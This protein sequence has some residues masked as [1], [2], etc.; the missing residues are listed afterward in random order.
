MQIKTEKQKRKTAVNKKSK[1]KRCEGMQSSRRRIPWIAQNL[2]EENFSSRKG[3]FF[4]GLF[5]SDFFHLSRSNVV[6][7]MWRQIKVNVATERFFSGSN[8]K[9]ISKT[10]AVNEQIDRIL[11]EKWLSEK[12]II[13]LEKNDCPEECEGEVEMPASHQ[14]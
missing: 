6:T 2:P 1:K 4:R 8:C 11:N 14:S 5:S 9:A 10:K 13:H 3:F 7:L 12:L